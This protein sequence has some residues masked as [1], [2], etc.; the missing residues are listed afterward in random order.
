MMLLGRRLP[1]FFPAS[2]GDG[3]H[4]QGERGE[5]QPRLHRVV[6]EHHLEVIGS[7]IIAP[8]SAICWSICCEQAIQGTVTFNEAK[9]NGMAPFARAKQGIGYVPQGREIFPLLTVKENL[10][11]G[12]AP[13]AAGERTIPDDIFSSSR[14]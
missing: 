1:A 5:G 11:T 6:L 4:A 13:L 3:E 2:S 9:L 10:E 12:F 14:C 7:T 8:P